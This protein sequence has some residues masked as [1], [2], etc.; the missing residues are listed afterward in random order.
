MTN[1]GKPS[2]L[3]LCDVE[4]VD[5]QGKSRNILHLQGRTHRG[6]LT[7]EYV[8][9]ECCAVLCCVLFCCAVLCC[10]VLCSVVLCCCVLAQHTLQTTHHKTSH[11]SSLLSHLAPP[12]P[13]LFLYHYACVYAYAY[14]IPQGPAIKTRWPSLPCGRQR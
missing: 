5:V 2:V 6:S 12:P 7:L 9:G 14:V 1:V 4:G 11:H 10:V 8:S 3:P 13:S